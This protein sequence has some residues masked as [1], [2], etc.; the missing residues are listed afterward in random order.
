PREREKGYPKTSSSLRRRGS[1]DFKNVGKPKTLGP[2]LRG[3]DGLVSGG[4]PIVPGDSRLSGGA[5]AFPV[6]VYA[7]AQ[8]FLNQPTR[9]WPPRPGCASPRDTAPAHGSR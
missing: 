6:W 1:S 4:F 3:D 8:E 7:G 2:R 5:G 9:W